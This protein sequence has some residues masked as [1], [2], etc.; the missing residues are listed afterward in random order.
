MILF[1]AAQPAN[2]STRV[3][4][5]PM[6]LDEPVLPLVLMALIAVVAVALR[7]RRRAPAG[8]TP[9]GPP[10][11]GPYEVAYLA[12]GAT[13]AINAALA[14]LV[15]QQVLRAQPA[16]RALSLAGAIPGDA[17]PVEQGI[18]VAVAAKGSLTVRDLHASAPAAVGELAAC[19]NK[20]GL[21]HVVVPR[22]VLVVLALFGLLFLVTL[23]PTV[24]SLGL[25]IADGL[26]AVGVTPLAA[27]A[28]LGVPL[29][30]GTGW[31]LSRTWTALLGCAALACLGTNG[32]LPDPNHLLC[33]SQ[34]LLSILICGWVSYFLLGTAWSLW[35]AHGRNATHLAR[36][37]SENAALRATA[38]RRVEGLAGPDLVMA[39]GLFG[40]GTFAVGALP[41]LRN[42]LTGAGDSGGGAGG[43]GSGC[44]GGGDGGGGGGDGG[45]GCGGG[46]GGCGG[47]GGGCGGGG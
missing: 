47:C 18:C 19:L 5:L 35:G 8:P 40:L 17:H 12:G 33:S 20:K 27:R 29:A 34:C 9:E 26:R 37:Q 16:E 6:D 39:A 43:C 31:A 41:D 11:L 22:P 25:L 45:G 28:C 14:N 36:L 3:Y 24:W 2:L 46:G 30:I 15:Q 1:A 42:A 23:G 21:S 7:W 4:A 38:A 44:G 32:R 13:R 10:S